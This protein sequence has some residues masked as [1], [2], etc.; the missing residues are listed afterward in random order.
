MNG[1]AVVNKITQP[2]SN[3]SSSLCWM[4]PGLSESNCIQSSGNLG[5]HSSSAFPGYL[6]L[7]TEHQQEEWSGVVPCLD[8]LLGGEQLP[9][10]LCTT[11]GDRRAER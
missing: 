8:V 7:H 9:V 3:S 6:P 5:T 1:S 4:M 11:Q 10:Q 2:Q